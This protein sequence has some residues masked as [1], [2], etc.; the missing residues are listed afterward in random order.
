M[1]SYIEVGFIWFT[2]NILVTK[3]TKNN[4]DQIGEC[5]SFLHST[6]ATLLTYNQ[7]TDITKEDY[8]NPV[9]NSKIQNLIL[10]SSAC[11]FMVDLF[12]VCI[13]K[14]S[15]M[16]SGHHLS[17]LFIIV[18]FVYTNTYSNVLMYVIF[19]A[20]VAVPF[21]V[22]YKY[23]YSNHK[24]LKI[25]NFIIFLVYSSIFSFTRSILIGNIL[26][27]YLLYSPLN[28][29]AILIPSTMI[30]GGSMVWVFKMIIKIYKK[31]KDINY[32][33]DLKN[34]SILNKDV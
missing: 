22:L 1:I 24:Q 21:Y 16:Y 33:V 10:F 19:Y 26:I 4:L 2:I 31:I 13:P 23:M 28:K 12:K 3:I 20:E 18:Y 29:M 30:Y 5:I 17:S 8:I 7:L 15:L 27:R 32:D 9:Q 25:V 34:T 6:S 14:R 11:Y